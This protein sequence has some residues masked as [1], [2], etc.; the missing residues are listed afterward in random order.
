MHVISKTITDRSHPSENLYINPNHDKPL[1][2]SEFIAPITWTGFVGG[3]H[4]KIIQNV[5][6]PFFLDDSRF[7]EFPDKCNYIKGN[8]LEWVDEVL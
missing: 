8:I 2:P 7:I 3:N 6:D 4:V 5:S 1:H